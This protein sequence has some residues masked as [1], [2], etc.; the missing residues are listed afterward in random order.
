MSPLGQHA[1]EQVA[2]LADDVGVERARRLARVRVGPAP[3]EGRG[4]MRPTGLRPRKLDQ[5]GRSGVELPPRL[6]ARVQP[7]AA[8]VAA[9][10]RRR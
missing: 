5:I 1:I 2:H 7:V 6:F 10:G 4:A 9:T 8:P 3:A